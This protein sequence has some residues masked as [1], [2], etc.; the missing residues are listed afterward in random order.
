[1]LVNPKY[2]ENK[3]TIC[4]LI[5]GF[6]KS[7]THLSYLEK[8]FKSISADKIYVFGHIF[9]YMIPP[10]INKEK[11]VYDN[12]NDKIDSNKLTIFDSFSYV[13]DN[14][15]KYDKE[16]Y[17]NRIYSQWL[18]IRKSFDLYLDFSKKN[19]IKCDMFIRMRSDLH[20]SDITRLNNIITQSYISNKIIFFTP[21][22][23]I[24]ND[25]LFIGPYTLFNKI[26]LLSDN[27][28]DYYLL[29]DIKKRIVHHKTIH[30]KKNY[31][32][33]LRF[34]GESEILLWKHI[35]ICL[36]KIDYLLINSNKLFSIKIN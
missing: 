31:N 20:I 9:N 30:N 12:I 36:K 16:G 26:M 27:I 32:K 34:G 2:N 8:L 28:Y 22:C 5:P 23:H 35:N 13:S 14:Y 7:Y 29:D 19:N 25:Q 6:I 15:T 3:L 21:S 33:E 24:V 10:N 4:I 18:N 1:M 11:I 17:D